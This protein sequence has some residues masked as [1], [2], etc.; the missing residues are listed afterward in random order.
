MQLWCFWAGLNFDVNNGIQIE[1]D[2]NNRR[3]GYAFV[4]FQTVDDYEKALQMDL[5]D[6]GN[7]WVYVNQMHTFENR[8][9]IG[10]IHRCLLKFC[11][12]L[13]QMQISEDI[14]R[15]QGSIYSYSYTESIN[16]YACAMSK[17]F[18]EWQECGQIE[19]IHS[20]KELMTLNWRSL[21]RL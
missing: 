21:F 2:E 16:L 8:Q 1:L 3:T 6:Q 20:L 7:P 10:R 11:I 4:E 17:N 15:H 14:P 19:S 13:C 12:F 5:K 9:M 18:E